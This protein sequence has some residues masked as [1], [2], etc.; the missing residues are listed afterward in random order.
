ME[1]P[2]SLFVALRSLSLG[3]FGKLRIT[4]ESAALARARDT[5]VCLHEASVKL[6][7]SLLQRTP[8]Y[9]LLPTLTCYL[10]LSNCFQLPQNNSGVNVS[11]CLSESGTI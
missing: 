9:V 7:R 6:H 8:T 3:R 11:A 10:V 1:V 5:G 2:Q 4:I